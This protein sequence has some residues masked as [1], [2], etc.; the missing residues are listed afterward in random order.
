[1]LA[2]YATTSPPGRRIFG[3]YETE[4]LAPEELKRRSKEH[5]QAPPAPS[6]R[7]L[8]GISPAMPMRV[9]SASGR[10]RSTVSTVDLRPSRARH[11]GGIGE[12]AAGADRS[13]ERRAIARL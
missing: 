1:M 11:A 7:D 3:R 9:P 2:I 6:S 4:E 12:S 13:C 10:L 5:E 8:D